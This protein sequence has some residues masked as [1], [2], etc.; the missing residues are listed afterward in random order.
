[1][2]RVWVESRRDFAAN[3]EIESSALFLIGTWKSW[4]SK[5]IPRSTALLH[6]TMTT[7]PSIKGPSAAQYDGSA[8]RIAI[9]HARWNKTVI[10]A[11]VNGAVAKLKE[12]GVK[13]SNIVIQSVPGSFELPIACSKYVMHVSDITYH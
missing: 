8:L 6:T 4:K 11:L 13:E 10:E 12:C 2:K 9:V 7:L 3:V 5:R 1:M